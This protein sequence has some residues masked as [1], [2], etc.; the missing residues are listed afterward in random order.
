MHDDEAS[1]EV[2]LPDE[3]VSPSVFFWNADCVVVLRVTPQDVSQE[4]G[5]KDLLSL[6]VFRGAQLHQVVSAILRKQ[7]V[8]DTSEGAASALLFGLAVL[9][10]P[11]TFEFAVRSK[12]QGEARC[13]TRVVP[14]I[15][16]CL[17]AHVISV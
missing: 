11:T 4:T 17:L 12:R 3:Y 5:E 2:D 1:C 9:Q 13:F 15:G 10:H 6:L 16:L 8:E 14:V 7:R